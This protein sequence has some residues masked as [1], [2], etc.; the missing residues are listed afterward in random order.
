[1]KTETFTGTS[2]PELLAEARASMG[3][4]AVVL[5]V[6]R[7]AGRRRHFEL[8]AAN[9]P[10]VPAEDRK[11]RAPSPV[12]TER[13]PARVVLEELPTVTPLVLALVG[14]TGAGKTT[15]I[16]KLAN[17]TEI[18]GNRT[19]GLISLD[20]FRVGAI[21]QIQVYADLSQLPLE[22]VYDGGQIR[23]AL[24]RLDHCDVILVDT[25]GRGPHRRQDS[26][27][28]RSMLAMIHP[29][30]VH[31]TL[32]GGLN[33]RHAQR[34]VDDHWD[35]GVTHLLPTKLDEYPEEE[36]L[37]ALA[38]RLFLPVRWVTN[39]Q[40]VPKNIQ[41]EELWPRRRREAPADIL[42][43]LALTA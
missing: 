8:L 16:A 4:D 18:F 15:T 19:V 14:P 3:T 26:R 2:I 32:P 28:I 9:P 17:H 13:L 42:D 22:V 35:F 10:P 7:L 40:R 12:E 39:G 30:E 37:F 25:P 38:E 43:S 5:S 6:R 11:R 31:L 34:L 24:R 20:T 33:E 23:R 36:T 41:F 27:V 1:M 21:E 29:T